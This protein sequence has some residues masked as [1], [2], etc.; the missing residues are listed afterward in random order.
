M[1]L[2]AVWQSV[3]GQSVQCS[4][5]HDLFVNMISNKPLV[6]ILANF[7]AVETKMSWLDFEVKRS[8]FKVT[9]RPHQIR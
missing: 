2:E 4:C 1:V 5:V 7:G 9:M 3:F 8:K 6:E